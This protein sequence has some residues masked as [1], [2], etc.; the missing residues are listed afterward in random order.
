M[1]STTRLLQLLPLLALAACH[2]G[3]SAAPWPLA[4]GA[5]APWRVYQDMPWQRRIELADEE[6][7][8]GRAEFRL[9]E[10][11]AF[12][13]LREDGTLLLQGPRSMSVGRYRITVAVE[14]GGR[15]TLLTF[16]LHVMPVV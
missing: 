8:P 11:P 1:T 12:V 9:L 5:A 3:S 16:P 4:P 14:V 13:T 6:V 7:P 2:G 15:R 10:A